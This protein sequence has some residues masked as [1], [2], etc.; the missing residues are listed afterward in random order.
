MTTS[1]RTVA[2]FACCSEHLS[3]LHLDGQEDHSESCKPD[4]A[5]TKPQDSFTLRT[6]VLF[7]SKWRNDARESAQ[8]RQH[9]TSAAAVGRVEEFGSGCVQD[10]VK[11]LRLR[12]QARQSTWH[13][14]YSL[15]A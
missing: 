11:I 12:R 14:G 1:L 7:S 9:T 8:A 5:S 13:C 6:K 2:L 15:S 3:V 4:T 10:S